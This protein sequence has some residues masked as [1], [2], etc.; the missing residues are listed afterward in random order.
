MDKQTLRNPCETIQTALQSAKT[1]DDPAHAVAPSGEEIRRS[2]RVVAFRKGKRDLTVGDVVR[3]AVAQDKAIDFRFVPLA[4]A[5]RKRSAAEQLEQSLGPVLRDLGLA[6]KEATMK[7]DKRTVQ[8]KYGRLTKAQL[9]EKL[10]FT[11]RERDEQR[12]AQAAREAEQATKRAAPPIEEQVDAA[13]R[14]LADQFSATVNRCCGRPADSPMAQAHR[15]DMVK[16]LRAVAGAE[17][18]LCAVLGKDSAV[19]GTVGALPDRERC[20][21]FCRAVDNGREQNAAQVAR[22]FGTAELLA[23]VA[24]EAQRQGWVGKP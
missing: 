17:R 19:V 3:A 10:L 8:E 12:A 22:K 24:S 16:V 4:A 21:K 15:E 5:D 13:A 7:W 1:L 2:D 20:I 6:G 23:G 9:L 18:V 11:L 14:L